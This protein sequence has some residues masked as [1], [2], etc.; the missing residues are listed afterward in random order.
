MLRQKVDIREL[1]YVYIRNKKII[2][3]FER[4]EP[5]YAKKCNVPVYGIDHIYR[6]ML[7]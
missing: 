7:L 2:F 4:Y 1:F 5:K 6:Y 3:N